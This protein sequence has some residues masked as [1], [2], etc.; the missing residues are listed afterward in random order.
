MHGAFFRYGRGVKPPRCGPG[1]LPGAITPTGRPGFFAFGRSQKLQVRF[2]P[3]PH[4]ILA[5]Y[6]PEKALS[7]PDNEQLFKS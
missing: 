7:A 6:L 1:E 3:H 5:L 4:F 2:T